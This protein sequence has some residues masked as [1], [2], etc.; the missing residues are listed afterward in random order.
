[1]GDTLVT[2]A[3]KEEEIV[4][5]TNEMSSISGNE[6]EVGIQTQ[7]N[8]PNMVVVLGGSFFLLRSGKEFEFRN[9]RVCGKMHYTEAIRKMYREYK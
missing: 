3:E 9:S 4:V 1:M 5:I 8:Y 2:E 6:G 7:Q